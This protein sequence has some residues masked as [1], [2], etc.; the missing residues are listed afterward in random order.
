[1]T[2]NRDGKELGFKV[3]IARRD[4]KRMAS[5]QRLEEEGASRAEALGLALEDLS[6][7]LR[8]EHGIDPALVQ[9]AVVTAVAPNSR[10]ARARLRAGDV[11]VEMNRSKIRNA[12][13]F[14]DQLQKSR[15]NR[16]LLL[17]HRGDG[18]FFTTL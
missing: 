3:K 1:V 11:I 12:G 15:G 5:F 13:D 17:V 2:V 8:R 9:G 6:P 14:Q 16:I 18:T 4:E 10:A 7:R